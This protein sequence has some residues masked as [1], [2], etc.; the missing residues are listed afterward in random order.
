MPVSPFHLTPAAREALR[1][2]ARRIRARLQL[3]R[4]LRD[5]ATRG[6]R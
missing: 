5:L 1:V 2:E 3:L 6:P 4:A